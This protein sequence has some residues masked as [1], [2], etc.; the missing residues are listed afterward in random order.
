MAGKPI[1]E[2]MKNTN[3][4]GAE[5][6]T[7]IPIDGSV[8]PTGEYPRRNNWY[9][10]S[11]SQAGRGV[12]VNNVW[13]SGSAIGVNF[14][15][16]ITNPSIFPFNQANET[17][18]G[19]SFEIDDTPGNER[20]LLKHHS[21]AG[22][23]IKPDG[24]IL[25]SSIGQQI[26]VVGGTQ[27]I[28]V[29]GPANMVYDGDVNMRVNGNYN[30]HVGGT[31]NVD[32]GA[33]HNHSVHGT[34]ITEVG[35]VH[36]TIVRGNKDVKVYGDTN[37]LNIG[38]R[39]LIAKK[40][41]DM[42]SRDLITHSNRRQNHT[43]VDY[44]TSASGK[45]TTISSEK[46]IITGRYGKVGGEHFHH[47]GSLFT[48]PSSDDQ[49]DPYNDQGKKTVFHGNLIGR[50]LEAW[51]AKYALNAKEAHSAHI[52]NFATVAKIADK[53]KDAGRAS[54]ATTALGA[55]T[56]MPP[57]TIPLPTPDLYPDWEDGETYEGAQGDVVGAEKPDYKFKWGWEVDN[58]TSYEQQT[59]FL[60]DPNNPDAMQGHD[61][62]QKVSPF[63][64]STE[65]WW[66]IWNKTSPFA[67][68]KVVIDYDDTLRDKISKIDGYT[69]YFRWS[70][71]TDEVRSKL[72]TM[73]GANDPATSPEKQTD[74]EKCIST[75]LDENRISPKYK[76]GGPSGD[77]VVNR[78]GKASPY[79]GPRFGTNLLGNPVERASKVV[80]PRNKGATSRTIVADPVYNVDKYDTPIVSSTKLSRSTTVSKFLGAPGSRASLEMIPIQKDRL[81]LA[82]QW[83]LHAWLMDGVA[84]SREFQNYRLQVLEGYY[85]PA[86]GIREE[87]QSAKEYW[88]EPFKKE[89]GTTAQPSIVKGGYEIN[90]LKHNGRAVVYQVVNSRGKVDYGAGFEMALYI[91]DT[92][93]YD[94]LSLD[95]DMTRPD[96][97]M[98]Q[99][100]IVVMPKVEPDY[101]VTFEMNVCTYF[102]R[103]MFDGGD[104]IEITDNPYK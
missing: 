9:G 29:Q 5:S 72:R 53:A 44:I 35:D 3:A 23:E 102:N 14:D 6:T 87:G 95:Y 69:Y 22:I 25:L 98:G 74:G 24:S 86:K 75:L 55:T 59:L 4:M 10:N 32:V 83:Y 16:P 34:Q 85:H 66:E 39:K 101:K 13:L 43:A 81:D 2:R 56:L 38:N 88:R 70:P 42:L 58:F 90:E 99:Q 94:Q 18:A 15:T 8:D 65:R 48:G 20:I 100:L 49:K 91:R 26:Q 71:T 47:I 97:V 57:I 11:I 41:I 19:H 89:D 30:L 68:R 21:G 37:E 50:A 103:Q 17:P 46:T 78:S 92:F 73:D 45:G 51:T 33:N 82:R 27:N 67:V 76:D 12:R 52:S 96:F 7:G 61:G 31:F 64:G 93:F 104:L 62:P 80:T 54:F 77:Y 63:Y 28:V 40:D 36:Q 84:S 79:D 60:T 1:N